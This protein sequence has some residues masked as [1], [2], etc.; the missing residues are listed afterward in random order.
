MHLEEAKDSKIRVGGFEI[1]IKEIRTEGLIKMRP[2]LPPREYR[3][4]KNRKSSR[5]VREKEKVS[6]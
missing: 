2:L 3:I 6:Y 1:D 5:N 4:L